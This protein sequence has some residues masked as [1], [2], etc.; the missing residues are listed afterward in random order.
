MNGHVRKRGKG[1]VFVVDVGAQLARRC[2]TEARGHV[3]WIDEQNGDQCP[4]CG[5]TLE[6]PIKLRRQRWSQT[7][8]RKADAEQAAR[9]ALGILDTGADPFPEKITLRALVHDKWVPHLRTQGKPRETTWTRYVELLDRW[10][11]PD[12]GNI[13]MTKVGPRHIQAAL[14]AVIDAGKSPRTVAHVRAATS[15]LFTQ[16]LRWQLIA[17]NPVRATQTPTAEKPDLTIPTVDE[18]RVLI[19][20]SKGDDEKDCVW[21]IPVLLAATTG[22]RRAEVLAMRWSNVDLEAGR[23]RIVDALTDAGTFAAP[24][25]KSAV[26][27]VPLPA[28]AVE[29][30]KTHKAAQNGRRL[31]L[32]ADWHDLDLVCEHGDGSPITPGAFT[33]GFGRIAERA[34]LGD[35]RLHDLRHGVATALAKSGASPLATSR[36]L[37]HA[38][39]AFT[40]AVY[41]H[42]DDE[43]V[44]WAA[45]GLAEAFG[46]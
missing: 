45:Q 1:W 15:A 23:V 29:R 31:A 8:A 10:V 43:M 9:K 37:G 11:L 36:M 40:Q 42:A 35:V 27:T 18:L 30:L 19:D 33:H 16:A 17:V 32:G 38:S 7:F 39:V 34:G 5:A 28:F 14:N 13:D 2:S 4:K 24:K 21:E 6:P 12:L 26:R 3:V 22:A 44:E 41:Q 20:A 25:T 46:S